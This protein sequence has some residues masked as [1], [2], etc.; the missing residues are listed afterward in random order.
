MSDDFVLAQTL[1]EGW[2]RL[3]ATA[4]LDVYPH[5]LVQIVR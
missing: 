3:V 2:R 5:R 4:N 1:D